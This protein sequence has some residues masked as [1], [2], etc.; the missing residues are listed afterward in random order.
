MT[1]YTVRVELHGATNGQ[2]DE[3]HEAMEAKGFVRWIKFQGAAKEQLP[4]AEYNM[5][6]TSRT[7]EQVHQRAED[8]AKSVKPRPTPCVLTTKADG[9]RKTSGLKAWED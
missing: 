2:Y 9:P 5:P 3:L 4:T 6:G 8:A 7:I 1:S